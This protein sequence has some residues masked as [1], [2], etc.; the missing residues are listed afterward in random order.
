M[1]EI[2]R[3]YRGDTLPSPLEY[4]EGDFYYVNDTTELYVRSGGA[5]VL[6][7]SSFVGSIVTDAQNVGTGTGL[8]FRN[9]TG[10]ILNFRTLKNNDGSLVIQTIGDEVNIDLNTSGA[11]API[12]NAVNVGGGPIEVFKQKVG[13]TLEFRTIRSLSANYDLIQQVGDQIQVKGL[14][15]TGSGVPI[16]AGDT[17]SDIELK[18]IESSDGSLNVSDTGSTI[19]LSVN[20]AGAGLV[21]DGANV[22]TGTGR[23]FRNKTGTTLNFRTLRDAGGAIDI[24]TAGD[25]VDITGANGVNLGSAGARVFAGLAGTNLQFRRLVAGAGISVVEN[26]S[27]IEISATSGQI[28]QNTFT[29]GPYQVTRSTVFGDYEW[30]LIGNQNV[31]I[32][33]S[34]PSTGLWLLIVYEVMRARLYNTSSADARLARLRAPH[35]ISTD[36]YLGGVY[37]IPSAGSETSVTVPQ[38]DTTPI[39]RTYGGRPAIAVDTFLGTTVYNLQSTLAH[40]EASFTNGWIFSSDDVLA[41]ASASAPGTAVFDRVQVTVKLVAIRLA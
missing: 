29:L 30:H 37:P 14:D 8:V 11:S 34:L 31:D 5:W 41:T 23:V 6:I 40:G 3:V 16:I 9:K 39:Y 19:D 1:M 10:T 32:T 17:G 7:A 38:S 4:E 36:P 27:D 26:A 25:N 20:A 21:A 13:N 35:M 24:A 2:I 22:G 15:N 28:Y 33:F 12:T 18:G